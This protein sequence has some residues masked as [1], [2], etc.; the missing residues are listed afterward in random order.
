MKYNLKDVD[1]HSLR[2]TNISVQYASNL[3]PSTT[4][5]ERAG[6]AD[7][8]VTKKRYQSLFKSDDR[9]TAMIVDEIFK[10]QTDT[11]QH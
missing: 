9:K 2:A 11:T 10:R 5:A 1:F 3:I 8:K 4:I 6:H 7:D